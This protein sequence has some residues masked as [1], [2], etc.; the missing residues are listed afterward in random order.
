MT[1]DPAADFRRRGFT[2][3]EGLLDPPQVER[4]VRTME[5]LSGRPRSSFAAPGSGRRF[6][7]VLG[8]WTDPDGVSRQPEMWDLIFDP[9]LLTTVRRLLG[10][11]VRYLQHS[12][13]HIGFSAVTWHR[14]CV[15]RQYRKGGDWDES[16][17][18]YRLLRVG[19]YLQGF[20]E[21][22]FELSLIP[23]SQRRGMLG[24]EELL[25]LDAAVGSWGRLRARWTGIDPLRAR[26]TRVRPRSGDAILFDPRILHCGSFIR[27][28]KYSIFLAYGVPGHHFQRHQGYY[29]HTRHELGYADLD[30]RLT[31][32][33]R[34]AGL[35]AEDAAQASTA[36]AYVPSRLRTLLG[37]RVR[38]A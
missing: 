16:E 23:G 13:L 22:G 31:D 5:I 20:A 19:I 1:E 24:E 14:D 26:A 38:R 3:I 28:A 7:G 36:D 35:L 2:L 10:T 37:R 29:R 34:A 11:D 18:P 32:R 27:G 17:E 12:D 8:A 4:C 15:N 30:P 9:L 25:A 6:R 21:N 33:L